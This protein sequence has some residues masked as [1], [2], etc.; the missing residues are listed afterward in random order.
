MTLVH[1]PNWRRL[2]SISV[3]LMI[4]WSLSSAPS[5]WGHTELID[6]YPAPG[7]KLAAPPTEIHLT[8]TE[9]N[10]PLSRILLFAPGFQS[11]PN[12]ATH[13]NPAAPMQLIAS[14]P[15]LKPDTYTV[16]WM[17][18][19]ADKHVVQGSYTF[20]VSQPK[21]R[22]P[23]LAAAGILAIVLLLLIT[24]WRKRKRAALPV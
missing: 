23:W 8:F 19:S 21:N 4:L 16:Q 3:W 22:G 18:V 6:A 14:L 15:L 20:S 13:V 1:R 7:A 11:I 10:D 2:C 24:F 9:P 5:L 12:V 17:A